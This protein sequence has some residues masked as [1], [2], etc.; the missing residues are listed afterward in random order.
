[1]ARAEYLATRLQRLP[2]ERLRLAVVVLGFVEKGQV[3]EAGQGLR[4]A[5][6]ANA[7]R[8]NASASLASFMPL[9]Y[10]PDL[11][12]STACAFSDCHCCRTSAVGVWPRPIRMRERMDFIGI[13][14]HTCASGLVTEMH[15]GLEGP[16]SAMYLKQLAHHVRRG[17]AGR[18]REGLSGGGLTYG[19]APVPGKRGERN[20]VEAEAEIIRR[21]FR[22][23]VAGCTPRDIAI[24]LNQDK[25][26]PPRGEFWGAG[27]IHGNR[28]RGSGLLSNALYDG[29]LVWNK[30]AMRKDPATGKRIS[31]INPESEWQTTAVPH[32]RIVDAETF[33]VA[34]A[35]MD[36]RSH[37]KP[38]NA[39]KQRHLLSGLLRCGS[40]GGAIVLK[41]RDAKGRRVYCARMHQGGG[42][43]NGRAFYL[44]DI[45]RRVLSGLE[46]QLKDPRA[47][48]RFLKTYV[49]E[50]RRLAAAEEAK[51]TRKET[52]LGEVKREFDRAFT[53]Y[54]KG[55]ASEEETAP[56][57]ATLREERKALEAELAVIEHPRTSSR[58]T[59]GPSNVT[60]K[61]WMTS[62]HRS[63]V[64]K[65][66][67][68]KASR[69]RCGNSS[70]VSR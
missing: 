32:L 38:A 67:A 62:R 28:A 13:E 27:T 45:T 5:R 31:R 42:C 6:S 49:E 47:I 57:L 16:M 33:K 17:Q 24:S 23:Y 60:S 19:Y 61:W 58:S 46:E 69:R 40:C 20:I 36:G 37:D 29:R 1:M 2:I 70:P 65:S 53:S 68:M 25:V 44:D 64:G 66:P 22:E 11:Y 43:T 51:R 8:D 26:K 41:D 56:L 55:F 52:R 18:V 59:P 4:G 54:V 50:R 9:T 15:A 39:R 30:V 48:E 7:F 10:W 3:V 34:Q 63:H 12:A 35:R 14:I 21:I